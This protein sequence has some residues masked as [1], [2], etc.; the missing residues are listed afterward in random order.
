MLEGSSEA[1]FMHER[2]A[3]TSDFGVLIITGSTVALIK[4]QRR[5]SV[6][7]KLRLSTL[8]EPNVATFK[9]TSRGIKDQ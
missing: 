9:F 6:G 2:D 1:Q 8:K 5:C 7:S 3:H 4:K